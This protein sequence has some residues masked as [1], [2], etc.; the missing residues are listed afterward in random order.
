M[1]RRIFYLLLPLALLCTQACDRDDDFE[2][3]PRSIST[4]VCRYW[5][6]PNIDSYTHPAADR[7]VVI[8]RD[9]PA[10][11]FGPA[12]AYDW[13]EI[14]GCG[15]P[16]PQVLLYD[17]LPEPLYRYISA[18]EALDAVFCLT[19]TPRLY[20]IRL[21]DSVLTYDPATHAVHT[22]S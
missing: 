3:L 11:T 17:Q 14:D 13:T 2:A 6:N 8:V 21:L 5:P 9:G 22:A 7:Y 18:T 12:P 4:F 10:L 16:L 1:I 20:T 19:R 15:L